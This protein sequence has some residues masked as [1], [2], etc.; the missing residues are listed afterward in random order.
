MEQKVTNDATQVK[1]RYV[2][3]G[4]SHFFMWY[5]RA[6]QKILNVQLSILY[7]KLAYCL[8]LSYECFVGAGGF[9]RL[10]YL[11]LWKEIF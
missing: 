1:G 2:I 4:M 6:T 7:S 8:I 3:P 11:N 5:F 10:V 9:G